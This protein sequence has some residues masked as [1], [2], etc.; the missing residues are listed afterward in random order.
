[1]PLFNSLI[2]DEFQSTG[3]VMNTTKPAGRETMAT[4]KLAEAK[5]STGGR[6]VAKTKAAK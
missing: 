2:N 4:M 6:C 3:F 1:V 5:Q